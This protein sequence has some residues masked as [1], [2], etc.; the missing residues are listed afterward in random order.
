MLCCLP[1]YKGQL[2]HNTGDF[3]EGAAE[4]QQ[5]FTYYLFIHIIEQS[6]PPRLSVSSQNILL[7]FPCG[8]DQYI[9]WF[10]RNI[11]VY[12]LSRYCVD[13]LEYNDK[14]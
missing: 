3:T 6:P 2:Y 1:A 4:I 13:W 5:A 14:C 10:I 12:N 8:F 9:E 11:L 7:G